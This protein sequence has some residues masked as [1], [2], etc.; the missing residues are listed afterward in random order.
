MSVLSSSS[1]SPRKGNV[2][3]S[4]FTN[5]VINVGIHMSCECSWVKTHTATDK[6]TATRATGRH[7][8]FRVVGLGHKLFMEKFFP[9]GNFLMS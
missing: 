6:V 2:L 7:L 1:I 5:C 8:T 4:K 3:V 9:P